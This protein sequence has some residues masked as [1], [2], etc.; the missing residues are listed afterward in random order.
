MNCFIFQIVA[1]DDDV[2]AVAF[3]DESSQILFSGGDDGL[4]KVNVKYVIQWT[5]SVVVYKVSL[6]CTY[7]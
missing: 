1:H 6:V 3:A 2:N 7:V 4:C 5:F